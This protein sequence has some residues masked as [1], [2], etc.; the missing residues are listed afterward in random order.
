MGLGHLN[1][2]E[3]SKDQVGLETET[4]FDLELE[5]PEVMEDGVVLQGVSW[6]ED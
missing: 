4:G 6:A 3:R 2:L 1:G 5:R